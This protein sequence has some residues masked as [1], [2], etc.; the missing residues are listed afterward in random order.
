MKN[1]NFLQS[2]KHAFIGLGSAFKK[3]RNFK[4]Y[5]INVFVT[6]VL[7]IILKFSL[8]QYCIWFITTC[9]VFS[10]ECFNTVAEHICDKMK[11]EFDIEIKYIKDVA[12]GGVLCWG[13]AFYLIELAMVLYNVFA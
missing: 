1:K 11:R 2:V 13:F 5:F 10:A 7:N 3:E 9:G 12:A 4:I 8:F 6:L